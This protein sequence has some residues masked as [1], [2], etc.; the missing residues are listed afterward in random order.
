MIFGE[1]FS[2]LVQMD[3]VVHS[4]RGKPASALSTATRA[5]CSVSV[6]HNRIYY[7]PVQVVN[8]IMASADINH[9]QASPSRRTAG[10]GKSMGR[11]GHAWVV[12]LASAALRM[13]SVE[14]GRNTVLGEGVWDIRDRV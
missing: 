6:A 11:R 4:S 12:T 5:A 3:V 13:A 7:S 14:M 1:A 9:L 2:Q 10:V 8:P